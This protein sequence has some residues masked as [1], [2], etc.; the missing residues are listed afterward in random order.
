M[1]GMAD[2]DV[3]YWDRVGMYVT[4][5]TAQE[6]VARSAQTGRVL[7]EDIEEFVSVG[8]SDAYQ[9]QKEVDA[10]F[11]SPFSEGTLSDSNKAILALMDFES[12]RKEYIKGKKAEGLTLDEAKADYKLELSALVFD[13]LPE[14]RQEI[15]REY[16]ERL[17]REEAERESA[18][19]SEHDEEE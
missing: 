15:V 7:D 12:K 14:E 19:D 5:E 1:G 4:R 2:E 9:M 8:V 3:R 10:L 17:E 18:K 11:A 13:S 16:R 6:F